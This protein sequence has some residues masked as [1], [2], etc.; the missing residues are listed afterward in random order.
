MQ[1]TATI[2][3]VLALLKLP[4]NAGESDGSSDDGEGGKLVDLLMKPPDHAVGGREKQT[5]PLMMDYFRPDQ[6][7]LA[8]VPFDAPTQFAN[9]SSSLEEELTGLELLVADFDPP[10]EQVR[11]LKLFL[12]FERELF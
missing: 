12:A 3:A 5:Q 10:A 4:K 1:E 6:D 7:R 9:A 2:K 11:A 8:V